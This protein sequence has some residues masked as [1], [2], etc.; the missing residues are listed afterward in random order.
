M[1][2]LCT[3][4]IYFT[5]KAECV[6]PLLPIIVTFFIL[7]FFKANLISSEISLSSML[8]PFNSILEMSIA[9]FPF[10]TITTFLAF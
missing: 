5:A 6:R 10:P 4:L 9:A 1:P 8:A 7:L 2:S 3:Y